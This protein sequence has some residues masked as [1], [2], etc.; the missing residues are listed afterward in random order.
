[1]TVASTI[2]IFAKEPAV[3]LS[4]DLCALCSVLFPD[5]RSLTLVLLIPDPCA[6][7]PVFL[8]SELCA[9]YS[10]FDGGTA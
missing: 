3:L 9:L 7:T 2:A 10:A 4:S 8:C 6:L 5:P 1:M